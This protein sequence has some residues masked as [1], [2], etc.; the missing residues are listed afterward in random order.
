M[1]ISLLIECL[2]VDSYTLCLIFLERAVEVGSSL[3]TFDPNTV[4]MIVLEELP[5]LV[6]SSPA[7]CLIPDRVFSQ[8]FSGAT[9]KELR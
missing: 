6:S 2:T 1:Q 4:S 8:G 7:G 9:E 5:L 3:Q